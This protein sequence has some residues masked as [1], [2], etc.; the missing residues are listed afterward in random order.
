MA[1]K[2]LYPVQ[3][4]RDD[5]DKLKRVLADMEVD[6]SETDWLTIHVEATGENVDMKSVACILDDSEIVNLMRE[7]KYQFV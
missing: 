2:K 7:M 3:V 6:N 5:Y 4:G 1:Q